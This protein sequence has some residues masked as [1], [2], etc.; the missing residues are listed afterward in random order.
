MSDFALVPVDTNTTDMST[1][2]Q[3][4]TEIPQLIDMLRY[5]RPAWSKCERTFIQKFIQPLDAKVDRHGNYWVVIP[6]ADGTKSKVMWS[7]HTDTVHRNGGMQEVSI[8][9]NH[10]VRA[11][12]SNC[13]GADCT[14]GVWLMRQMIL[15]KVPGV[16]IFHRAEEI[17]GKG[18][19]LIAKSHDERL[20]GIDFAIAFDRMG[21]NSVITH[22]SYG[23]CCSQK[24]VDSIAPMLPGKYEAD[25]GGTFT[26]T[27]SYMDQISECTN[28]SVGYNGQH[29]S[30][31][32]QN[33]YH[34]AGLAAALL[35][36]DES[37]LVADRDPHV[38]DPAD[39]GYGGRWTDYGYGGYGSGVGT[40]FDRSEVHTYTGSGRFSGTGHGTTTTN[41]TG[42]NWDYRPSWERDLDN[43]GV[44]KG[45]HWKGSAERSAETFKA[46]S[47][48]FNRDMDVWEGSLAGR[49]LFDLVRDYPDEVA[50]YLEQ[51]GYDARTFGK[52]IGVVCEN[53]DADIH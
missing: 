50:D 37:K 22:Q 33:L 20:V 11:V 10:V 45:N 51:M 3:L 4:H 13:L 29:T 46:K 34:V 7:S 5:K 17:G 32:T 18:S 38:Y 44:I 39:D 16:Y 42:K 28:L 14:T 27:A 35:K 31:E 43:P 30:S 24:F 21:Y 23:R 15:A 6:M 8:D 1:M 19:R 36:F 9:T 53:H 47:A 25:S 12:K 26:D 48:K 49:S 52:E 41:P 40:G 2:D